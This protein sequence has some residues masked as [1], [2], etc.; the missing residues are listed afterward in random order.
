MAVTREKERAFWRA[1][2]WEG[3]STSAAAAAAR[4]TGST[5]RRWFR[6]RGGV[7]PLDLDELS[8]RYLSL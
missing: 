6:D 2:V 3:A 8:G 7:T 4:V 5:A 1:V